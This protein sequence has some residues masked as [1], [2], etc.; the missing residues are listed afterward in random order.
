MNILGFSFEFSIII[1]MDEL[2]Y[3]LFASMLRMEK[4]LRYKAPEEIIE[5]E[6]EILARKKAVLVKEGFD[7]ESYV[8]SPEGQIAYIEFC[9]DSAHRAALYDRCGRC[10]FYFM[11]SINPDFRRYGCLKFDDPPMNCESYSEVSSSFPDRLQDHM[12]RC[13]S[14]ILYKKTY[15]SKGLNEIDP[16]CGSFKEKDS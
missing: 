14:C 1:G 5:S 15:C 2:F 4:F 6:R 11:R 7:I 13:S 8:A 9:T 12:V 16:S 3:G 10:H